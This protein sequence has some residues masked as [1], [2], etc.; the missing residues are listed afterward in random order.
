M[1]R[2]KDEHTSQLEQIQALTEDILDYQAVDVDAAYA[3]VRKRIGK[4]RRKRIGMQT[5]SRLAAVL[6]LPL[7]LS[8]LLFAYLYLDQRQQLAQV[9]Y[10]EVSCAPG[11]IARIHLPDQSTVWL[12]A[13]STL[14]YPVAFTG[15]ERE[16][17]LRGEGYFAVE[18]DPDHP[19]YVTTAEGLKVKAYGTRFNVNAYPDEP[20]IEATLAQ[21][22][23]DVT[24]AGQTV[25]LSPAK[26]AV[27][28]KATGQLTVGAAN[29]DE[30]TGWKDGR[31]VFRGTPLDKVLQKL[32]KRYNIDIVLHKKDDTDYKYRATFT[33]ET[34]EQILNYLKLTAPIE[35]SIQAPQQAEDESFRRGRIDVYQR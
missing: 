5:F 15:R 29:L 19:F 9:D 1:T 11:T 34:I 30:K 12:N 10:R 17:E 31:L 28:H 3:H 2:E 7:L 24:Q 4:S 18:S 22:K 23:I 8:S 20:V 35:W 25:R 26:L 32:S 21:G 13:G 16:V 6:L 33:T 14:R 27:F